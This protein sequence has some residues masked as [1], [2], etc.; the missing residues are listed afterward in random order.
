M[1]GPPRVFASDNWSGAHPEVV[2]AVIRANEGHAPAYGDD[3]WTERAVE[4]FQRHFGPPARTF[5]VFN[6]TGANVIALR[7]LTRILTSPKLAGLTIT[8]LNPDHA[9]AVPGSLERF[10]AAV[11]ERLA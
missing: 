1:S 2:E 4:L 3:P 8:E 6:G 7:A 9:A 10:A 5:F 11:G